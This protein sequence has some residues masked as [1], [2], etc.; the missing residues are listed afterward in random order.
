MRATHEDYPDWPALELIALDR[1]PVD[2]VHAYDF[3]FSQC[4]ITPSGI[5]FTQAGSLAYERI[6]NIVSSV[7]YMGTQDTPL[8][9]RMRSAMRLKRLCAKYPSFVFLNTY[10]LEGLVHG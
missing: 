6:E 9:S 4:Y 5:H 3:D 1:D 7:R 8:A 10:P 2:D